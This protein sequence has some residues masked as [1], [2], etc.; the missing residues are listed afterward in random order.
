MAYEIG[1]SLSIPVRLR[2]L[3]MYSNDDDDWLWK[4][5][6]SVDALFLD[7]DASTCNFDC[8]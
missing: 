6:G 5:G 1:V 7:D 4:R 8:K 2:V 3:V